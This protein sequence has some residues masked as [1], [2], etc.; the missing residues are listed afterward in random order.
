MG[1]SYTYRK[2]EEAGAC[3]FLGEFFLDGMNNVGLTLSIVV[4][5]E[6]RAISL[7]LVTIVQISPLHPV[8]IIAM[9]CVQSRGKKTHLVYEVHGRQLVLQLLCV[10]WWGAPPPRVVRLQGCTSSRAV[11]LFQLLG[12][13]CVNSLAEGL[14]GFDPQ[15]KEDGEK[16]YWSDEDATLPSH[17]IL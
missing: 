2:L 7:L 5:L 6:L 15:R 3:P 14:V 9:S 13:A 1:T 17:L 16:H 10:L 12:C 8:Q 11:A 4:S